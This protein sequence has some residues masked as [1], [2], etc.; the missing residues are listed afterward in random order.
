MV[1]LLKFVSLLNVGRIVLFEM[2]RSFEHLL[3]LYLIS[4]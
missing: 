1:L 4:L 3:R 2:F